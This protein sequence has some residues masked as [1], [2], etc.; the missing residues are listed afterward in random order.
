MSPRPV[1]LGGLVTVV[2]LLVLGL[3]AP[4]A[5]AAP[6][7]SADALGARGSTFAPDRGVRA[8]SA[9]PITVRDLS[10]ACPTGRVPASR[11]RDVPA[12][13]PFAR[14]IDCLVW[15]RVTQGTSATTY[16]PNDA[17]TR[18]QMAVFLH[19][20]LDDLVVL[21]EPPTTSAFRDVPATGEAGRAINVLASADLADLLGVQVVAGRTATTF[22]PGG[23]VSRAQMGSFINRVL[24]GVAS[25][26]GASIERGNCGVPA[27]PDQGCFPDESLIPPTHR[28]NVAALFRMGIVTGR[29]DGTYGP[30][31]D[32]TRGQMAA[33]LTRLLDVFVEAEVTIPPD[34]YADVYVD[35]GT[36]A[37]P[38]APA[39][40]DGSLTR[41]FC[42]IQAGVDRARALDGFVVTVV[43]LHRAG[44]PAYAGPVVLSSGEAFSVDLVGEPEE[45]DYVP[46]DGT[47]RIDGTS[48]RAANAV[49]GFD[50]RPVGTAA[51]IDVRTNGAAFVFFNVF[52]GGRG[53][54]V[55]QG[56]ASAVA[57]NVVDVALVGVDLVRTS[58]ASTDLA[59]N[60]FL[61][62]TD[63]YVRTPSGAP[64]PQPRLAAWQDANDFLNQDGSPATVRIGSSGGRAALLP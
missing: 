45:D 49:V 52:S 11:F 62:P 43:V 29:T 42:T 56:G 16:A 58:L 13:S 30:A 64:N 18:R 51:A 44:A 57:F 5:V 40:R 6:R 15:Y 24:E 63:V 3:L 14:A 34:R 10:D 32:V 37:A 22:D 36:V 54:V 20:L 41:P 9:D 25:Y 27:R 8:A 55:D 21:P 53:I 19:R 47:I 46:F 38:C 61:T 28:A 23:R 1:R 31:A 12:G 35:A 4:A 39:G 7:A 48:T 33:F 26:Y 59:G 60:L 2:L 17:V 50:V